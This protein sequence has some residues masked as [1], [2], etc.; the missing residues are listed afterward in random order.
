VNTS[1]QAETQCAR[2]L[3]KLCV[4][5]TPPLPRR[6][7]IRE[8][9]DAVCREFASLAAEASR[10]AASGE[11][12]LARKRF[13]GRAGAEGERLREVLAA[14]K[15]REELLRRF[16]C[17]GAKDSLSHC[18]LSCKP[19]APRTERLILPNALFIRTPSHH[20]D[21]WLMHAWYQCE[22]ACSCASC[23]HPVPDDDLEAG[24]RASDMGRR[25]AEA[26]KEG[27]AA[28]TAEHRSFE[29]ALK[30]RRKV[31]RATD[32][33]THALLPHASAQPCSLPPAWHTN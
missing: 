5:V 30:A 31:S 1:R 29:G 22:R 14:N 17:R 21:P 9:H 7:Q 16:R 12:S 20:A 8:S 4:F 18:L 26:I 10:P 15:A 33:C 32:P 11:A 24:R 3:V 2:R 28:A 27:M 6:T 23:R 13:I 25:A 19:K